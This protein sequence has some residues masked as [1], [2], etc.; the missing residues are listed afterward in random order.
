MLEG[1]HQTAG[2]IMTRNVVTVFAHTSLR[3]AAKLMI[4]QRISGIPVIDA[5]RH[6]V[7]VVSENDLLK[8]SEEPGEK[9]VRWLDMLA[10][11]SPLSPD[12]LDMI[13]VEHEKV[14]GVMT[15]EV[16]SVK[17][18]TPVADIAKLMVDKSVKR[19]PVVRDGKL[20][21]IVTR[22]DLVRVLAQG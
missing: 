11:G 5:E 4:E 6:V 15:T 18:D 3:Y 2:D 9:Q 7:G 12:F 1:S 14:R 10:E 8:W 22:S 19:V 17:E 16:V 13:R 21:G 20:A